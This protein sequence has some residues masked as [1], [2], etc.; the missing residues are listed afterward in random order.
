MEGPLSSYLISQT[1]YLLF[2]NGFSLIFL[3]ASAY[4][5][6]SGETAIP[7]KWLGMFAFLQGIC[8]WGELIFFSTG[9]NSYSKFAHFALVLAS[10]LALFEFGRCVFINHY[11]KNNNSRW[12]YVILLLL[13]GLL[14]FFGIGELEVAAF[15]FIGFPG[16]IL[17]ALSFSCLREKVS[18]KSLSLRI[19]VVSTAIYWISQLFL[20]PPMDFLPKILPDMDEI[21]KATGC[22]AEAMQAVL[23]FIIGTSLWVYYRTT[24][25][26]VYKDVSRSDRSLYGYLLPVLLLLVLFGGWMITGKM[27]IESDARHRLE[28]LDSTKA[29]GAS[30]NPQIIMKLTG[31]ESDRETP[32]FKELQKRLTEIGNSQSDVRF[33]YIMRNKNEKIFFLIDS[34]PDRYKNPLDPLSQPGEIYENS[35]KEFLECFKLGKTMVEGP[36]TDEWGTW[37]SGSVPI[38][39]T[40][41]GETVGVLGMDVDASDWN[42][43]I[44]KDRLAPITATMLICI[45]LTIFFILYQK[46]KESLF[47]IFVSEQRYKTLVEGATSCI[48]LFDGEG[49]YVSINQNGLRQKEMDMESVIGKS[50]EECWPSE[51]DRKQVSNAV[52][53]VLEGK[54][55]SFEAE[56]L[57]RDGTVTTWEVALNPIY[58]EQNQISRFVAISNDITA[59]K[60]AEKKLYKAKEDSDALNKQLEISIQQAKMLAVQAE[61]ANAAK[62]EFLA[63]MSHE[64]RTPM[65]GILGMT[66]ILLDSELSTEQGKSADI[67]R[68]SAEN[69][70]SIINDILDFS[71]IE[72][73]IIELDHR[74]F[75]LRQLVEDIAD[76]IVIKAREKGIKLIFSISPQVPILLRGDP[77]RLR[78]IL[79]N[80]LGNAVKFTLHGEIILDVSLKNCTPRNIELYF[81]VTDTGIGIPQDSLR[82]LF[83]PFSQ[84]D[85]STSRKFGGTG[86]GLS[87]SKR[88]VETMNGSIGVESTEGKG[89]KFYFTANFDRQDSATA[90]EYA[91][92]AGTAAGQM[93]RKSFSPSPRVLL[94]EDNEINQ[95]VALAIL[96][97]MGVFPS[98]AWNGNEAIRLMKSQDFD[99]V[100]MDVQMPEMSGYEVTG[101]VRNQS[102]GV[103]NHNIPIIAMTAHAMKGDREKCMESG[104]TD[105]ISKPINPNELW[106]VMSKYAPT[107]EQNTTSADAG[108]EKSA[109]NTANGIF[110]RPALMER[111]NGDEN[112]FKELVVIFMEDTPRQIRLLSEH[113]LQNDFKKMEFTAHTLKGS[114]GNLGAISIQ[115]TA[116]HLEQRLKSGDLSTAPLEA[117]ISQLS[118]ELEDLRKILQDG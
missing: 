67:I 66:A 85:S 23:T 92:H 27:G 11:Q 33:I 89:S 107:A 61:S 105:Y 12:I 72:A 55:N 5:L 3:S 71:K 102:S 77:V 84:V 50:Y 43:T 36:V 60:V 64:I 1:D 39:D 118:S 97:K 79:T 16:G 100:L 24:H 47:K 80:I 101:I 62:S 17:C 45:M 21:T 103:K 44:A 19:A 94:V 49:R 95:K 46:E 31:S 2:L 78:Q 52:R 26:I 74:D 13:V 65:N 32:E 42:A 38:F 54:M 37:I 57:R 112:L 91:S 41:S 53:K 75:N 34:E 113:L 8:R 83:K 30:I 106:K 104:M 48:E 15:F 114:A 29:I 70:L 90:T 115:K 98:Q 110:D 96:S 117:L 18:P 76:T 10:F 111:I 14:G 63:N 88:L 108:L 22:P 56:T 9:Q 51:A 109:C 28:L 99:I 68:R 20:L 40:S 116:K 69:L 4:L 7:W 93:R 87:I 82:L 86:L 59:K 81:S 73:G 35:T 6:K 58:D 25:K